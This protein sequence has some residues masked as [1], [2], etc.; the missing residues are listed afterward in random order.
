MRRKLDKLSALAS[1]HNNSNRTEWPIK[2]R[3]LDRGGVAMAVVISAGFVAIIAQEMTRQSDAK[4][5]TFVVLVL[6]HCLQ[7]MPLDFLPQ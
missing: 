7:P 2:I 6:V 5:A 3:T 4:F 1:Y